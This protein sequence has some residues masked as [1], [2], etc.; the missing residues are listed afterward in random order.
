MFT[1]RL[2]RNVTCCVVAILFAATF[3]FGISSV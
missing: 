1:K 3:Y 2:A